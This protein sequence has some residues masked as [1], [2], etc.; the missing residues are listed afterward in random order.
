MAK[1]V[2][3][4]AILMICIF[5]M[6]SAIAQPEQFKFKHI[7]ISNGLTHP[8]V[9]T[10]YKDSR[11]FIWVGTRLGLN[12]FDGF[13]VKTFFHDPR[14]TTSLMADGIYRVFEAPDGLLVVQTSAGLNLYNS[15]K[16]NFDRQLEPFFLKYGTSRQVSNVVRDADGSFWFVEPDK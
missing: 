2:L 10:I 4:I 3:G 15:E 8:E 12:R 13:T 16:E 6:Q 11:G 14:D 5:E 9:R 7:N 1:Y